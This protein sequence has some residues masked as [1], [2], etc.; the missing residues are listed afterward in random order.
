[1]FCN[2]NFIANLFLFCYN[3]NKRS[4]ENYEESVEEKKMALNDVEE[5]LP[6]TMGRL[7]AGA[8]SKKNISLEEL[9]Q[10]VM[11]AADLK[12]IEDDDEYADKTTWDFLLGRLGISPLIYECYVE[13]DEYDLFKARKEMREI[14]NQ[15]MSN[16]LMSNERLRSKNTA[17]LKPLAD[18][19]EKRS[20]KYA[21]LLNNAENT[22]V[23]IHRI[24]LANMKG[25]AILA[26]Q[27][28]QLCGADALKLH[29]ES[30]WKRIYSSDAVSWIQK[31]HKVLMAVYEQE[32]LFLLAQGYEGNG[33]IEKAIQILTGLWEQRKKGGD[34]EE[35][36]RVLSLAAWKLAKLEWSRKR[37][38]KAMEICQE[39]IDR[40]IQAE[41]F[42]GLL[43]LLKQRLFFEKQ[44]K[45][46]QEEWDEQ[47][48]TIGVIDELFAEFHENPY[49]LFVLTTFENARI[50]D[51]IIRIR[52]KEQNLTQTKLSEGI[53]E[54]ESYSRFECGK[55]KL[56]WAK[57]KKLLERLGERGNKVTLLLESDDPDVVEEYQRI[58]DSSYREKYDL[59]K[60]KIYDLKGKLDKTSKIN[61]QFILHMQNNIDVRFFQILERK[62]IKMKRQKE[63]KE[64]ASKFDTVS[65]QEHGWSRTEIAIIKNIANAYRDDKKVEIAISILRKAIESFDKE[66]IGQE[67]ACLGKQL[68]WETLAT[69]LGDVEK[70]EDAIFYAKKSMKKIL[71]SGSAKGISG[72][73]YEI[74]WN[75]RERKAKPEIYQKKYFQALKFTILF[76]EREFIIFLKQREQEYK[77]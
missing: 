45:C 20:Q 65:I 35:N 30:E 77:K 18:Q 34:P 40:S 47:E 56:R 66:T 43:P 15:I 38:E 4:F 64:T 29:M 2:T 52:R 62:Q 5:D 9:S 42:R 1:M 39:A 73:L 23:A 24:F 12:H 54:P 49:G 7:I 75:E 33:E 72:E 31:P 55:R 8:R 28:G 68:L 58:Q 59:L 41:S 61:R 51:E 67:S 22:T 70:Y 11:S 6:Y 48:K 17:Q 16:G 27:R 37:Q 44:L 46:S 36:T 63:I 74:A 14:S 3:Y 32:M 69:Y 19:L 13:Q 26:K 50:A 76:Q 53:L 25:Y 71:E 57:K 60:E 10:G 21:A